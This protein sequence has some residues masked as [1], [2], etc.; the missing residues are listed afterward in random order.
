MENFDKCCDSNSVI[1][2]KT[3]GSSEKCAIL[4]KTSK[5]YSRTIFGKSSADRSE[6]PEN[7]LKKWQIVPK[8]RSVY[9]KRY[10]YRNGIK[11]KRR[12]KKTFIIPVFP[13]TRRSDNPFNVKDAVQNLRRR[14]MTNPLSSINDRHMTIGANLSCK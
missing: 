1:T 10:V 9:L 6:Q 11:C 12:A 3:N 7:K 14:L 2:T 8:Y 5:E 13:V 4:K